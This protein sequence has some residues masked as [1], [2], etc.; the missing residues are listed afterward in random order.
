MAVL[1]SLSAPEVLA[2]LSAPETQNLF[3]ESFV[4]KAVENGYTEDLSSFDVTGVS[5]TANDE[6]TDGGSTASSTASSSSQTQFSALA[7]SVFFFVGV[8]TGMP[9]LVPSLLRSMS[10]LHLIRVSSAS[11]PQECWS[12]L[13]CTA[14]I[15]GLETKERLL[16]RLRLLR[17]RW[18]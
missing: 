1:S 16:P 4:D 12:V 15:C 18:R 11:T 13:P 9:L 5:S 14:A 10:L 3:V 7:I 6:E 17:G 2:S 8:V